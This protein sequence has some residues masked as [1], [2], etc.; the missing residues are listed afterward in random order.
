M[1]RFVSNRDDI[2]NG[3]R[4]GNWV[5]AFSKREL[6]ETDALLA[7]AAVGVAIYTD[8]PEIVIAYLNEVIDESIVGIQTAI[9]ETVS[10]ELR[11][12]V[13]NYALPAIK[14]YLLGM[15][16]GESNERFGD[17]GI[18]AGVAQFIGHNEEWNPTAHLERLPFGDAGEWQQIGP[19]LVSYCPYVGLRYTAVPGG[20]NGHTSINVHFRNGTS[21]PVAFYLNGGSGLRTSLPAHGSQLYHVVVDEGIAPLVGIYQQHGGRLDFSI[22]NAGHYVFQVQ[23]GKIR[24]FYDVG[25]GPVAPPLRVQWVGTFNGQTT[26]FRKEGANWFEYLDGAGVPS[27]RFVQQA[28]DSNFVYLYDQQ[29]NMHVA[30]SRDRM[31]WKIG[32]AQTWS[33]MYSGGWGAVV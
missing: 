31:Y 8:D 12:Q 30:L 20:R 18:K 33:R 26:R 15:S 21:A 17:F 9:P 11:A 2:E 7:L 13:Q 22:A 14:H 27:H 32:D 16:S 19:G 23:D 29:R 3:I 4:A 1:G 28:A 10:A 5:V 24:N 25:T 6:T